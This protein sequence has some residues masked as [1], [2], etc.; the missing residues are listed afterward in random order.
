MHRLLN[1]ALLSSCY[2]QVAF[3]HKNSVTIAVSNMVV[4]RVKLFTAPALGAMSVNAEPSE[5]MGRVGM[6]AL[7]SL[8][9]LGFDKLGVFFKDGEYLDT[10]K[11]VE[12][13]GFKDGTV[14]FLHPFVCHS[15]FRNMC[16]GKAFA[17]QIKGSDVDHPYVLFPAFPRCRL[18]ALKDIIVANMCHYMHFQHAWVRLEVITRDLKG[19][20]MVQNIG[21]ANMTKVV[22]SG[23]YGGEDDFRFHV[24]PFWQNVEVEPVP[25]ALPASSSA[26]PVSD[27]EEDEEDANE[28][29]VSA[30][31]TENEALKIVIA[32]GFVYGYNIPT[33]P[34]GL[35]SEIAKLSAV[36][37]QMHRRLIEAERPQL[38]QHGREM[39][40]FK[41]ML[42]FDHEASVEFIVNM[43]DTVASFEKKSLQHLR[44]GRGANAFREHTYIYNGGI[45]GNNAKKLRSLGLQRGE[46]IMVRTA[47]FGGV[48]KSKTKEKASDK[49]NGGLMKEAVVNKKK[50]ELM[51]K[52]QEM[53]SAGTNMPV[54]QNALH[55]ADKILTSLFT[56][57]DTSPQQ[58]F[59]YILQQAKA[60]TLGTE[61]N[62]KL[63]KAFDCNAL[64]DL[65]MRDAFPKLFHIIDTAN[66]MQESTELT[67]EYIFSRAFLKESTQYD[68]ANAKSLIKNEMA[69]RSRASSG[70]SMPFT[71]AQA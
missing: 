66:G 25:S 63:L 5:K 12:E 9:F 15:R 22:F 2:I 30:L 10:E 65:M 16:I 32:T 21:I 69:N 52:A 35:K 13:H 51:A 38:A 42:R 14:M 62:S 70:S 27:R 1:V 7:S 47:G 39:V 58:A 45:M 43:D 33:T 37:D 56:I 71:Q 57:A 40:D 53:R 54:E 48:K 64:H 17:L 67:F 24:H 36:H 59:I 61:D 31:A 50:E 68:W 55:E 34:Q 19:S 20:A 44:K 6:N 3:W 23:H 4:L 46:T 18:G 28:D 49:R 26:D 29:L 8:G 11:T 60:E 41:V